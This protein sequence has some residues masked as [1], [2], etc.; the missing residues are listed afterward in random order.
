[1]APPW[2]LLPLVALVVLCPDGSMCSDSQNEGTTRALPMITV[3]CTEQKGCPEEYSCVKT[4][5]DGSACCPLAQGASCRD[6]HHCCPSGTHC[7]EDGHSCLPASNQS[8]VVCPDGASECPSGSTCCQMVDQTW[9]CCPL[10]KATCCMDHLHCCPQNTQCDLVHGTC[11]S[12]DKVVP[13]FKKVPARMKLQTSVQ[14]LRTPCKDGS[15]CPDGSTC[16]EMGEHSFGCCP[17]ISAVCC[18]D[19]I[20]CCP[21]GT[22]CDIAH[23]K[24]V[25]ADSETPMVKKIPALREEATVRCDATTTCPGSTTCCRLASGDWGCCPYPQAVCCPDGVH[26]CPGGYICLSDTCQQGQDSIP[27]AKKMLAL[28]E[29]ATVKCD[30]TATC[31]GSTTC[32][33]LASGD[34]GCCP[35]EKAVCCS[36]KIHC[37]PSGSTCLGGSC[38]QGQN[39]IPWLKKIPALKAQSTDVPCDPTTSCPDKTTCCRLPSGEWGCCPIEQA[40]CCSDHLHCCPSGYTCDVT[41]ETCNKPV[42]E[43]ATPVTPATP[44]SPVTPLGYVWCDGTHACYDGQTCCTGPGGVWTCC[45]YTQGVCCPDRLHCCPYG[46]VC[47]NY[48]AQCSRSGSPLWDLGWLKKKQPTL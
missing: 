21:S 39:S 19:H 4:P 9:G 46:H 17:L 45:P 5:M 7:S 44:V 42:N 38:Q 47:L 18:G 26:C 30:D 10:E 3:F 8:A 6:G 1:M 20:H 14:V 12:Q 2:Y 25:S 40:V 43:M 34:W 35:Y 31:P 16:C 36:D 48:G 41:S 33:R 29:E 22:T 15:S 28:K 32:C 37:C 11:V 27:W 24:C 13:M 23:K